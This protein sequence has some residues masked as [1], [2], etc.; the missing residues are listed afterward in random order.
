MKI[1]KTNDEKDI[2]IRMNMLRGMLALV[3]M[4]SHIW[5]Y[6]GLVFLV[7]FNKVV[8]I[9]VAFFFF[10]SGYGMYV[11]SSIKKGYLK[12]ILLNKIP[13]LLWMSILAYFF[14]AIMETVLINNQDKKVF[15]PIS[16]YNFF[17]TT[18]WYV[19]ELLG[20]YVLF[21]LVMKFVND[22]YRLMVILVVSVIAFVC[23]FY[24]GL[25]EAYYNSI[26]GFWI[27][28]YCGRKGCINMLDKHTKGYLLGWVILILSFAAMFVLD[29]Q[30]LAFAA[31]RNA[32]A[33][34]ALI[35]VLYMIRYLRLD[36]K[37][38][39][40]L[41]STSPELY[42]YHMPIALILSFIFENAYI[43]M[44]LVIVSS[45]VVAFIIHPINTKVQKTIKGAL[46]NEA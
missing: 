25:V 1:E 20:F 19:Y 46:K 26:I 23:L 12:S 3:V 43:Y 11:S 14:S 39:K 42:F 7:P 18:N 6:T 17:N 4:L 32:A 2:L 38:L 28:M 24:S 37:I 13:Y 44:A 41:S 5:G 21:V 22:K 30:S 27:G 35:A 45:Y 8:T 29:K 40:L 31:I 10:L 34:G 15:S 36:L 33:V 9:A 16:I